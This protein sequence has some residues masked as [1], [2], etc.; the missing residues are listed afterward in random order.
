MYE[1][2][3]AP[4]LVSGKIKALLPRET[5]A[6]NSSGDRSSGMVMSGSDWKKVLTPF[7]SLLHKF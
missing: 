2:A 1:D 3:K 5:Y 4:Q 6:T 7:T